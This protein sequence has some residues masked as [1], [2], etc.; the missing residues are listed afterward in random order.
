MRE[1]T[2]TS[3]DVEVIR[4]ARPPTA[5]P[6]QP[7]VGAFDIYNPPSRPR[8]AGPTWAEALYLRIRTNVDIEGLYGPI[9]RDAA[10]P[11]VEGL[12]DLLIGEPALAGNITW[13]KMSRVNRHARHGHFKMAISAL[14]NALWDIRGKVYGAPVWQLLG[15]SSRPRVPA[16]ASTLGT[17]LE[18]DVVERVARQVADEGYVAQKWFLAHGPR[19]GW[20]GMQHNIS[21]VEQL[22]GVVGDGI[23]LMFDA[24]MGWDL[25]YARTWCQAVEAFRPRWLE[26]PFSPAQDHLYGELHRSTRVPLAMGEHLY[27]RREV[28]HYLEAT[29]VS[30]MQVDPEWCGGVTDLTRMCAIA[31][32]FGVPVVPHGHG[33]HAALHVVASQ[34]PAVCPLVEYLFRHMPAKHY[35]EKAPPA[36]EGGMFDLPLAPGF[37]I[38]L[39]DAKIDSR[40]DWMPIQ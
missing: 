28:L 33:V 12:G 11:I 20:A 36:P 24:W 23:D 18:P 39:D 21:L 1:V 30:V 5:G 38:D 17:S 15:G 8:R 35:F 25:T 22:R 10:W 4:G 29:D 40:R 27:D 3:V 31:E 6:S 32:T 14:D 2:V 19:E 13:D 26:E 7:Q 37:G 34:S 16:Y 9:D